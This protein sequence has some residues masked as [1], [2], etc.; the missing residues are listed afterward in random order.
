MEVRWWLVPV[1]HCFIEVMSSGSQIPDL[2]PPLA[3]SDSGSDF[4]EQLKCLMSHSSTAVPWF[5]CFLL[6][7]LDLRVK[8]LFQLFV[9]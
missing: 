7:A 1:V 4:D 3:S 2:V 8:D 6:F 9:I 5:A